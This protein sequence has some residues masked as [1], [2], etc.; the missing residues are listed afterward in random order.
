M[1]YNQYTRVRR[2]RG[3]SKV[4]VYLFWLVLGALKISDSRSL[5]ISYADIYVIQVRRDVGVVFL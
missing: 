5:S 4:S 1:A 2:D 3:A